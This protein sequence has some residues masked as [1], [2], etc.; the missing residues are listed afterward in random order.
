MQE[1]VF[2]FG[3]QVSHDYKVFQFII[4]VYLHKVDSFYLCNQ[5]FFNN[6]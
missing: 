1:D 6:Y 3:E 4:A 2:V 5:M